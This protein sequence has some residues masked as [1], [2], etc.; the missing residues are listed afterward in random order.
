MEVIMRNSS[1]FWLKDGDI[2]YYQAMEE[3]HSKPLIYL[4]TT[5][6]NDNSSHSKMS[7]LVLYDRIYIWFTFYN[8]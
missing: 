3:S 4:C 6:K 8:F 7:F 5:M 2:E 1:K